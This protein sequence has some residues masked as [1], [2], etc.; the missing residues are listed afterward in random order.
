MP[1]GEAGDMPECNISGRETTKNGLFLL[2]EDNNSG[3][4][5][6]DK[7]AKKWNRRNEIESFIIIRWKSMEN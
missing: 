7:N 6:K 5:Q 2:I 1:Q 3:K 4:I